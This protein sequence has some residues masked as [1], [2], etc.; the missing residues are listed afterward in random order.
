MCGIVGFVGEGNEDVLKLM[1]QTIKHRG[2]DYQGV[3]LIE[4]V[5]LAHARLSILDLDSRS[6]QPFFSP[7]TN[8]AIVFN[9][10]IYNYLEI[11]KE[12]L[13]TGKYKF[14]TTSDTEVLLYSYIEYGV[15][16]L[17]KIHGMFAF[18]IYNFNKNE[19]LLARDRMGKKPLYYTHQN[20]TLVFASELKAIVQHPTV[21]KELNFNA[22]NEYLTFEYIPTPNSIFKGIHKLEAA[23]YL[24][25]K[26]GEIKEKNLYWQ[27]SFRTTY[28]SYKDAIEKLDFLMSESVKDRLMSDV[29]LGVFLSG[30]IDSSAIAYYAQKRS[31]QKIKTFSIGFEEKSYDESN[32]ARLLANQLGTDHYEQILNA[33]QSLDLLPEIAGKLDE[34]FADPSIIPTYFLSKFTRQ[35]VT[36]AL[37]GDGSDELLAGYPT[38]LSERVAPF[39]HAMPKQFIENFA[40]LAKF[41]PVSDDNI[42]LDFKI[43]Q[44]LKGFEGKESYTHTLWLGSFTPK[45]KDLLFSSSAK[46]EITNGDGLDSIERY[47]DEI[48]DLSDFNHLLFSYYKTYLLEDILVKVDRASM[49]NS[50][51]V[52]AP[53]LD[54]RV[55]EFISSLPKEYKIKGNNGKRILKD[56]MRSKIPSNIIDRPKKGFGI[57]ISL[58]L[59]NELKDLSEDLLSEDRIRQQ[60]IFDYKYIHRLKKEHQ[61]KTQ[62][63]RKLL[64]NL[65]MFQLWQESYNSD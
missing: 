30:G 64:W 59:R 26:D 63:H 23:S 53:F 2:P 18:G 58:W 32:Y 14:S 31:S 47:R 62:N 36:V 37:G 22:L 44:F 17:E 20:N 5:G 57:P 61:N 35:Y 21:K 10:E 25:Y 9:G 38:F 29:P 24:I 33:K 40:R 42:S 45:M 13:L 3:S 41:L 1:V 27:V 51:E 46:Q 28:I 12:L 7:D 19:L 16:C 39:F 15:A 4:N 60:G 65:M 55:V 11:K 52:R 48:G 54:T 56:L 6:N 43:S 8:Y 49:F 34:P 50:L